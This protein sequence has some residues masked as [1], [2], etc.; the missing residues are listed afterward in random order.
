MVQHTTELWRDLHG[1]NFFITGGTGFYGKWLLE[2]IAAAND[3]LGARVR[4]TILSRDPARFANEV[5]HLAARP[6]FCCLG[7]DIADFAFPAGQFDYLFHFATASAAEV[8]AGGTATIMHTLRGTER[9]LHF[10]RD[11]GV[12]RMLFASSGAVYGPQPAE[13][14]HIPETYQGAPNSADPACSYA[15]MKRISETMCVSSGVNCVTARGFAFV[16]PYLPLT[17]K[18]AVGSF[19]RDALAGGPIRIHGDGTAVRSYLYAADL[20]VWLVTLLVRGKPSQ[21]YN[22]GSDEAISLADLARAVAA[23]ASGAEV[24]F[25]QVPTLSTRKYVPSIDR[26]RGELGLEANIRVATALRRTIDW[27][28]HWP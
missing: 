7:G 2:S 3:L 12:N 11:K 14:S 27:S 25:G 19:V 16:G 1:A 9:V 5:P 8:G 17:D 20:A 10:A 21:A 13:L 18:F 22:V 23:T 24:E 4:A 26:A 15:E 28:K 6:E